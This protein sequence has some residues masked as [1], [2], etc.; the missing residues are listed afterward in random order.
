MTL[1][2]ALAMIILSI[3]AGTGIYVNTRRRKDR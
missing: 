2:E 3:A 1:G